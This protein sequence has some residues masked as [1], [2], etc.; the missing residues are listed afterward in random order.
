MS[1]RFSLGDGSAGLGE[2][3]SENA[4]RQE[5][6]PPPRLTLRLT[7]D[8]HA[9][10]KRK[11]DD[12]PLAVYV[13]ACLFGDLASPRKRRVNRLPVADQKALAG[14]LAKL[15][16]TRIANNLNQLA[17]AANCGTLML[18]ETT[19]DDLAEACAHIAWIRAQLI[20]ALGLGSASSRDLS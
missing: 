8:E 13:R 5:A 3:F 7:H 16:E 17:Y 6:T 11:A 15:G 10:L 19:R 4:A 12:Q 20:M 9:L 2:T 18:D 14:V 1:K